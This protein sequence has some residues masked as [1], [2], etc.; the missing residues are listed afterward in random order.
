MCTPDPEV[1]LV[2]H[3]YT[4]HQYLE[5]LTCFNHRALEVLVGVFIQSSFGQN[6]AD[7]SS[8]FQSEIIVMSFSN[9]SFKIKATSGF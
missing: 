5:Q 7:C 6:Q 4:D 3:L 9:R 2:P 1:V 8:C